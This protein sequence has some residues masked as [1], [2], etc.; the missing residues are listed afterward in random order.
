MDPSHVT[1]KIMDELVWRLESICG[2][3]GACMPVIALA[4]LVVIP[5]DALPTTDIGQTV[6]ER[7]GRRGK[8][9]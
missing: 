4:G 7:V 1:K 6:L 3:S 2:L 5:K 9:L 8:R